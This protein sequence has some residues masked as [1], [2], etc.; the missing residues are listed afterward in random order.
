MFFFF[1]FSFYLA[2][3]TSRC[4]GVRKQSC[5]T[6]WQRFSSP[7]CCLFSRSLFPTFREFMPTSPSSRVYPFFF[8]SFKGILLHL[9]TNITLISIQSAILRTPV[10]RTK[11]KLPP[12]RK[13]GPREI[14]TY[15]D[16]INAVRTW[17]SE[18]R[19]QAVEAAERR[20][21]EKQVVFPAKS[22]P[23]SSFALKGKRNIRRRS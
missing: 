17:F 22:D 11:L 16:T 5:T 1:L 19:Q 10:I 6:L 2:A 12:L 13:P 21:K 20:A 23:S 18:N 15:R 3:R 7:F 8:F 14:P 4:V 9:L